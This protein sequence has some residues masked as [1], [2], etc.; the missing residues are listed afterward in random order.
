MFWTKSN[1]ASADGNLTL[2]AMRLTRSWGMPFRLI[3]SSI[4]LYVSSRLFMSGS[5]MS[6]ARRLS[7]VAPL[8]S[9]SMVLSVFRKCSMTFVPAPP[10][11]T[12][13]MML[14]YPSSDI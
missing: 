5:A 1:M 14:E 2:L 10:S 3:C 8:P 7:R 11:P 13:C 12:R 4:L 6:M 9:S